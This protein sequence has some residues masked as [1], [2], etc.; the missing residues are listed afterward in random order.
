MHATLIMDGAV[1]YIMDQVDLV[2]VGA[3]GVVENGGLINQVVV[4]SLAAKSFVDRHIS[5]RDHRE[6][7]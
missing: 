1:G 4:S 5:N 6:G 7:V 2:L 3:E